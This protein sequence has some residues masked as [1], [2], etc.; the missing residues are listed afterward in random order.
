MGLSS[1]WARP[2]QLGHR[3]YDALLAR[4]V[5]GEIAFGAPLRVDAIARQLAISTTPV[6]EALSRL[7]KDALV[8]KVPYQGWFVRTFEDEEVRELYELRAGMECFGVRPWRASASRATS[9][10]GSGST[11]GR[12]RRHWRAGTSPRIGPTTA[13]S[14]P[15]C[16]ARRGTAFSFP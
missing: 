16:C 11:S 8:E 9:S 6:R 13:T 7:E 4:I 2:S 14:T 10:P 5:S 15:P 3:A 12:E 1:P